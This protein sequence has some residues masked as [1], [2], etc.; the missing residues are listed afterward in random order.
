MR[1]GCVVAEAALAT[2]HLAAIDMVEVNPSLAD[3]PGRHQ[4]AMAARTVLLTALAG[5][6]GT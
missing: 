1:E 2:G 3:T 4:T 5:H 6:R